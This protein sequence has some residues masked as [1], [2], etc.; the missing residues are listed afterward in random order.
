MELGFS[1]ADANWQI[2]CAE[3]KKIDVPAWLEFINSKRAVIRNP[4]GFLRAKITAGEK[5]PPVA[6]K[7]ADT[8]ECGHARRYM[9]AGRCLI[10]AGVVRV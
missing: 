5:P 4:A 6:V 9:A 1:E 7:P 10:C 8:L 2:A 3:K